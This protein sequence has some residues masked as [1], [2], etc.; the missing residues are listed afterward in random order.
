MC[1]FVFTQFY[2]RKSGV[3]VFQQSSHGENMMLEIIADENSKEQVSIQLLTK[4]Q[5]KKKNPDKK[6]CHKKTDFVEVRFEMLVIFIFS[7]VY[8]RR[9]TFIE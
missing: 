1:C 5:N 4:K 9:K 7:I 3:Q 6:T 2:L 8:Y